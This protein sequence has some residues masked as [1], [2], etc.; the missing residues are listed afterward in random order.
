MERFQKSVF[1]LHGLLKD[2]LVHG[3]DPDPAE[4]HGRIPRDLN[5]LQIKFHKDKISNNQIIKFGL[6]KLH[7]Y[8][9]Y[10][11]LHTRTT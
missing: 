1:S 2:I 9:M 5:G 3:H 7:I 8:A 10:S 6:S 11:A 4:H